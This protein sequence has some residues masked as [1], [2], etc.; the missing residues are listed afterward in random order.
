MLLFIAI[1]FS[2]LA[3]LNEKQIFL[4]MWALSAKLIMCQCGMIIGGDA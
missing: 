2:K 4:I 3:Q 1:G